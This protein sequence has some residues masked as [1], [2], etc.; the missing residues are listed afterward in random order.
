M[1]DLNDLVTKD[2]QQKLQESFAYATGFGVVFVDKHGRHIGEGSNFTRFC[3]A[4]NKTPLGRECCRCSNE[5]AISIG[6]R[7]DRPSI[8]VCHAGLVN[9]EIPLILDGEY[10]GAMTAGQVLCDDMTHFPRDP[11]SRRMNWLENRRYA[12]Y[13]GEIATLSRKQIEETARSLQTLTDYILQVHAHAR[14]QNE[15]NEMVKALLR[16]QEQQ[17]ELNRQ[18]ANAKFDALQKQ[19]MPHFI[20]NVLNSISRLLDMGEMKK[21]SHMLSS[22]SGMLRYNLTM[23][24]AHVS[25]RQEMEHVRRYM[26][27]QKARFD[28]KIQYVVSCD[29][30][31]EDLIVPFCTVQPIVENAVE[32]G[33]LKEGDGGTLVVESFR[34]DGAVEICVSDNGVG[35]GEGELQRLRERVFG[36][37]PQGNQKLGVRNCYQRLMLLYGHRCRFD[38]ESERGRGTKVTITVFDER[39]PG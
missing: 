10:I 25:L 5:Q 22:F 34:E 39:R 11:F 16:A 3:S 2:L 7:E 23:S 20:F 18:L 32:H 9:I 33:L 21:A 4:V 37:N 17:M 14:L 36:K 19:V 8:Y 31:T 13:Y 28:D 30:E 15:M 12:E 6:L 38:L 26:D 27:I 1:L 24:E 29:R 35:M